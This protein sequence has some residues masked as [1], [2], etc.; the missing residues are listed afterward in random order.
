MITERLVQLY[1][2]GNS[3]LERFAARKNWQAELTILS[4]LLLLFFAFPSYDLI[5][6]EFLP[7]WERIF[8]QA[9]HPLTNFNYDPASHESKQA[10]RLLIPLLIRFTGLHIAGMIVLQHLVGMMSILLFTQ[11]AYR[12]TADKIITIL[13]TL[14]YVSLGVGRSSFISNCALFDGF[15]FF[16]LLLSLRFSSVFLIFLSLTCAAWIDE[17]GLIASSLIFVWYLMYGNKKQVAAVVLAWIVYFALRFYLAHAFGLH[18][19]TG[20][21]GFHIFVN[22]MNNA[23]M[24]LWT[25]MEGFWV[26][27]MMSLAVLWWKKQWHYLLMLSGSVAIIA[28]VA[29]MVIDISR[30]M[31]YMLPAIIIALRIVKE[32]ETTQHFSA[33]V[34]ITL[35]LSAL[36]PAYIVGDVNVLNWQYPFPLQVL[37]LLTQ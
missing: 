30:S 27:F 26:M 19:S 37:R 3:L 23:P 22:Q 31:F 11:I 12:I 2:R 35:L 16:F 29:L 28:I 18:T 20:A 34:W 32:N 36:F 9:A 10:F 15:A 17:R 33:L 7:F 14:A 6:G 13:L 5:Y 25:G 21:V 8:V 4:T 24:G 1:H